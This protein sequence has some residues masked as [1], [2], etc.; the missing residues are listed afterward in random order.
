M[1]QQTLR[2]YNLCKASFHDLL[3]VHHC[4]IYGTNTTGYFSHEIQWKLKD[5]LAISK[6]YW[7]HHES[8]RNPGKWKLYEI[9]STFHCLFMMYPMKIWKFQGLVHFYCILIVCTINV[10]INDLTL[11]GSSLLFA[12]GSVDELQVWTAVIISGIEITWFDEVTCL[13]LIVKPQH[14]TN[15]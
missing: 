1:P 13:P 7:V 4:N 6:F 10:R 12:L 2:M 8:R 15:W 11:M 9:S 14:E 5:T 3:S